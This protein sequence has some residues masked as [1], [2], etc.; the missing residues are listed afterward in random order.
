MGQGGPVCADRHLRAG[1]GLIISSRPGLHR[2]FR[3]DGYPVDDADQAN[4]QKIIKETGDTPIEVTSYINL[5]DN[6]MWYGR[7]ENRN[8][9]MERW[10]PYLRFKPGIQFHYVYFY[11]STGDKGLFK[12]NPGMTV[13]S[14]AEKYARSMKIDLKLFRTPAGDPEDDRPA[15]GGEQV[16]HAAEV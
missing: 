4:A 15:A 7:P 8:Q 6:R 12:Y 3:R 9:D 13:D 11:D 10:E 1:A 16:C 2:V 5:L 14:L